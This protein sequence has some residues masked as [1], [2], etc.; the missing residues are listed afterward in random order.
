[1]PGEQV[2]LCLNTHVLGANFLQNTSYLLI[3]SVHSSQLLMTFLRRKTEIEHFDRKEWSAK[4]PT[5][6]RHL[7]TLAL[8]ILSTITPISNRNNSLTIIGIYCFTIYK[9]EIHSQTRGQTYCSHATSQHQN[10]H[11]QLQPLG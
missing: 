7:L 4:H 8:H 3:Y 1:M 11:K 2:T 10:D 9:P 6:R 5:S